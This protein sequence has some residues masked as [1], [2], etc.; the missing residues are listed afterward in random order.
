MGTVRQEAK[1]VMQCLCRQAVLCSWVIIQK[2]AA[3]VYEAV[4]RQQAQVVWRYGQNGVRMV[5]DGG[6][7]I[8]AATGKENQAVVTQSKQQ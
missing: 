5:G 1:G 3:A 6:G 4:R 7:G 8:P 2:A